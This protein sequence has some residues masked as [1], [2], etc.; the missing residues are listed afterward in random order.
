MLDCFDGCT[1]FQIIIGCLSSLIVWWLLNMVLSPRLKIRRN[2][3]INKK[4]H[5]RSVEIINWTCFNAYDVSFIAEYRILNEDNSCD[6]NVFTS[7]GGINPYIKRWKKYTLEL[8]TEN[9]SDYVESFFANNDNKRVI[10][11]TAVYHS[12][13]GIKKRKTRI[14]TL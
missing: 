5:K 12:K 1:A 2:I 10:V 14:I 11:I 13:I 7:T 6:S 9:K 3:V 4:H 8:T